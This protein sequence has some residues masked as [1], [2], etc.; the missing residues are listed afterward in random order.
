MKKMNVKKISA[1]FITAAILMQSK[2]AIAADLFSDGSADLFSAPGEVYVEQPVVQQVQEMPKEEIFE[3]EEVLVQEFVVEEIVQNEEEQDE[4]MTEEI[5]EQ[6]E[7]DVFVVTE[8]TEATFSEVPVV[9]IEEEYVEEEYSAELEE[10]WFVDV[11]EDTEAE[12]YRTD[13]RYEDA[14]AII[15]AKALEEAQLPMETEMIVTRLAE[16]TQEFEEAKAASEAAL[17]ASGETEY[18]FYDVI[19]VINGQ[20]F[21]PAEGTVELA[22]E[23]KTVLINENAEVQNVLQIEETEN[24]KIAKDVTASTGLGSTMQSVNVAF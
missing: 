8:E 21:E 19:F 13:F 6:S 11:F 9:G 22:I 16:G 2:G 5:T 10:D 7:M 3:I 14:T 12:I 17:G 18:V 20:E 15:T 4:V 23:F 24:G 1:L